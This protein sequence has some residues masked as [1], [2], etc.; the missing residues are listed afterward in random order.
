MYQD[1]EI[2]LSINDGLYPLADLDTVAD[3]KYYDAVAL[4]KTFK[5]MVSTFPDVDNITAAYK[6]AVDEVRELYDG[7]TD[8]ERRFVDE[9]TL[10]A[11]E[12]IELRVN[13][14]YN[15]QEAEKGETEGTE[16]TGSE[17]TGK[18][19]ETEGTEGTEGTEETEG[20]DQEDTTDQTEDIE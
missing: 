5:S 11:F 6:G 4:A 8:Y 18:I 7:M 15:A 1:G 16:E 19:E 3:S 12:A 10:N 20:T 2:Y 9:D 14:L 13:E 17:E